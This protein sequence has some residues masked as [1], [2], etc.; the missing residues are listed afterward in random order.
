MW[1]AWTKPFVQLTTPPIRKVSLT[2]MLIFSLLLDIAVFLETILVMLKLR[3]R[4]M[5]YEE[6]INYDGS[7]CSGYDC[8]SLA[9][10]HNAAPTFWAFTRP[11]CNISHLSFS[12]LYIKKTLKSSMHLFTVGGTSNLTRTRAHSKHWDF[13]AYICVLADDASSYWQI[14]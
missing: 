1:E 13:A 8:P 14:V 10:W 3:S 12:L 11:E 9:V 7:S 6:W 2:G 4:W 5:G